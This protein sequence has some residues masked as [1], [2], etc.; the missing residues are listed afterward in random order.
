MRQRAAQEAQADLDQ[1]RRSA[2]RAADKRLREARDAAFGKASLFAEG[3]LLASAPCAVPVAP[4]D[5]D[6]V[7]LRDLPAGLAKDTWCFLREVPGVSGEPRV[8]GF[9]NF[10]QKSCF[11][12][13]V[14]QVLLRLPAVALWLSQ[15][16]T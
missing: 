1:Q 5:L 6:V 16:A 7:A 15:H 10:G 8:A 4:A 12:T 13:V 2:R 14:L 9:A 3:L 11:A